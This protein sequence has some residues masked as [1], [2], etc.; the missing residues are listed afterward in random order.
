MNLLLDTHAFLWW[1]RE[2]DSLGTAARSAIERTGNVVFVSAASA[3]EIAI[4][5]AVGRLP[6]LP[7][8]DI[9]DWIERNGFQA[10]SVD[11][12]HAVA[13]AELPRHH[14]DPFDRLLIAQARLEDLTLVASDEHISRYRVRLLDAAV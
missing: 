11:V 3:L 13:S 1:L 6:G 8:G 2:D 10:L 5:R 4:K 14:S 12:A 7:R 9:G